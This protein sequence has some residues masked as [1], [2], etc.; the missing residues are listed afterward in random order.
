MDSVP[1]APD[2]AISEEVMIALR[3]EYEHLRSLFPEV[4]ERQIA[5]NTMKAASVAANGGQGAG[6]QGVRGPMSNAG[7]GG[8]ASA[9]KV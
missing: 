1:P 9:V 2:N 7:P 4:S 8:T 6:G 3:K 5:F